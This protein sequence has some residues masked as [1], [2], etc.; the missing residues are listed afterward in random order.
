MIEKSISLWEEEILKK[1]VRNN[2]FYHQRLV[3][4]VSIDHHFNIFIIWTRHLILKKTHLQQRCQA[5]TKDLI[6][7]SNKLYALWYTEK[8]AFA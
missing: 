4:F 5:L 6:F 3:Y 8:V 7:Y 1:Q 2:I